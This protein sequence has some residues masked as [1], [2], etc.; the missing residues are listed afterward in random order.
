MNE[1]DKKIQEAL[2]T[3][4]AEL[5]KDYAEEP[6]VFEMLMET[7]RGR[8]RWLNILGAFWTLV[9]L[10]LGIVA[11]VKF[12]SAEGTRDIVMWAAA[13]IVCVSAVSMLK[14]WYF[15]EMNK[16]AVTREIK[17]LELQIARLAA[18]IKD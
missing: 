2:R 12:F 10:V 16:N 3:E 17:R 15:L 6:S 13:C 8:H 7:C 5:F 14:I 11:A 4:D 9:F 1:L 18:R